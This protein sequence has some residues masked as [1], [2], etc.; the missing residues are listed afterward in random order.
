MPDKAPWMVYPRRPMQITIE[1]VSPVEKKVVFELPWTDVAP[2]LDKAYDDLRKEVHLR[3]FRPGKA[4]RQVLERLY[5]QHVEED[6]A[7][8]LVE[9]SLGEAIRDK[10]LEPVAPARVDRVEL[11]RD[12]PFRFTALVEV[13]SQVEPKDYSGI[14]VDRRAPAV[15]DEQISGTLEQYRRQLTELLPVDGRTEVAEGDVVQIEVAGRVGPH[16]IKK[17]SVTVDLG[18]DNASPLPGLNQHLRGLAIGTAEPIEVKYKVAE[19]AQPKE[20]VGQDVA[21][22]V[23]IKEARAKQVP[24]IDDDLAKDTGEADTLADLKQKVRDRLLEEDK[25]RVRTEVLAALAKELVA[26]NPFPMAPSVIDRHADLMVSRTKVQFMMMG[27]ETEGLDEARMKQGMLAEA[28]REARA[29][30]LLRAIA[31]KEGIEVTDADVQKRIAEMAAA[32]Q[33]N[34]KKLRAEYEKSGRINGLRA[35]ILEEK[36]LDKLLSLA[37]ITDADPQ[38]LIVTP[39][40]A[41]RE[42]AAADAPKKPRKSK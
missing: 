15:T 1:D 28:E 22:R 29:S 3:G 14:P 25:R 41:A 10:Q 30:V 19:D 38:R 21:L 35:Q 24:A 8:E 40:E 26:R 23:S 6:V 37:K 17:T 34:A 18:D 16:K 27:L 31:A 20:L 42:T 13:R 4:P 39:E 36:T 2:R 5:K 12:K 9:R 7:R 11:A 32:R 33:E